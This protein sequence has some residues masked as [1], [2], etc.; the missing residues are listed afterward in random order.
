MTKCPWPPCGVELGKDP[1]SGVERDHPDHRRWAEDPDFVY[2]PRDRVELD[3][4]PECDGLGLD[5]ASVKAHRAGEKLP[6]KR[7]ACKTCKGAGGVNPRVTGVDVF[8][9]RRS[10]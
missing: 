10:T 8:K 7:L 6:A 1:Q 4:C 5:A 2:V 9:V 3:P